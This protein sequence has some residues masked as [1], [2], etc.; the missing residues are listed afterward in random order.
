[1]RVVKKVSTVLLC[2]IMFFSLFLGFAML[3]VTRTVSDNSILAVRTVT[4]GFKENMYGSVQNTLKNKLVSLTDA[5]KWDDIS[6]VITEQNIREALPG[7]IVSVTDRLLGGESDKWT[8]QNDALK[9]RIDDLLR[10][11]TQE[12]ELEYKQADSDGV[13]QNICTIITSEMEVIPQMYI[14]AASP[15]IVKVRKLCA[16]WYIP[17]IVYVLSVAGVAVIGRHHVKRSIYNLVLPS[18]L[19]MFGVLSVSHLMYKKDYLANV[20]IGNRNFQ[21][22]LRSIYN[23]VLSDIRQISLVLSVMLLIMGIV[24]SVVL[25]VKD[26]RR[27]YRQNVRRRLRHESG[28]G[29]EF[30]D[31]NTDTQIGQDTLEI[32]NKIG[33]GDAEKSSADEDLDS[34]AERIYDIEKDLEKDKTE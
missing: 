15:A 6:D 29:N 32:V 18:Y 33:N 23:S 4:P 10:A 30:S 21:H 24:I 13:Y 2:V 31:I 26:E 16:L 3:M 8:Y 25:A 12:Y 17:M 34:F 11:Y 19:A 14:Y 28:D 5:V 9:T 27:R 7:A 20:V 22:L 1:M